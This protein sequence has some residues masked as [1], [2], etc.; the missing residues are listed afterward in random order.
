MKTYTLAAGP[1]LPTS[2][3]PQRFVFTVE[4]DT[5]VDVHYRNGYNERGCSERLLRL[6][7]D[8]ALH[9]V[10][11]ICGSCSHAHALAFC[12]ALETLMEQDVPP[13]A[14]YLRSAVAEIERLASHL[15]T[16]TDI[17]RIIAQDQHVAVLWELVQQTRQAMQMISGRRII[18]DMCLPG[19][20]RQDI[21]DENRSTLMV[22][23]ARSHRRLSAFLEQVLDDPALSARVVDVGILVSSAAKQ[24]GLRGPLARASGLSDDIRVNQ[25]YAA[26]GLLEVSQIIEE[27]GDVYARMVVLLLESLESI[28]L[29]EQLLQDMPA[30]RYEGRIPDTVPAGQASAFVEGPRGLLRYTLESDG[31]RLTGVTI[32]PPRQLDRL[33]VRALC[34]GASVDNIMLIIHSTDH[35]LA[36]AEC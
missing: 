3:A 32:D 5:V 16:L 28:K 33:L 25:P 22:H 34:M 10:T 13:R 8:Q 14:L 19:G 12:Q 21:D 27:N 18:P 20:V 9:L 6:P 29:I 26:Y 1:F 15:E 11:R 4:G 24:F 35:C 17:F 7:L 36:C 23:L 30:G 2:R 31:R